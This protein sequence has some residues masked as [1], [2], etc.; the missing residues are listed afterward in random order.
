MLLAMLFLLGFLKQTETI[1][2]EK[3]SELA[4]ADRQNPSCGSGCGDHGRGACD[5]C[6]AHISVL[7]N[8]KIWASAWEPCANT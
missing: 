1:R 6:W 4:D 7:M 2:S 8:F 3:S 5:A